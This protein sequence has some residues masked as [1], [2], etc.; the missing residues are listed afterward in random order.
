MGV[1]MGRGS[2]SCWRQRQRGD[3]TSPHP[4]PPDCLVIPQGRGCAGAG[5]TVA[6]AVNA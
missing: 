4:P 1:A 5:A 3:D 6:Q 2:A